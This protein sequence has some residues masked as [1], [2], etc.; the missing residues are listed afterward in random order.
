MSDTAIVLADEKNKLFPAL[1][2]W[3]TALS[4]L[5]PEQI[6]AA[7]DMAK[8]MQKL[9]DEVYNKLRDELLKG[10]KQNGAVVTA[11]GSMQNAV[12]G[13]KVTAIPT[14]TGT[15]AKK[16]E[17]MLRAKKIEPSAYMDAVL[18][19]K[20]NATKAE[21]A[22]AAGVISGADLESCAVDPA[23]RVQVERE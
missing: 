7:L 19:L 16:F 22:V 10:V 4:N 18:T 17:S 6:P 12:G 14:R 9:S 15:D 3:A 5:Q 2:S 23:Y 13:F 20:F 8:Q 21:Q 1:Q 11:K